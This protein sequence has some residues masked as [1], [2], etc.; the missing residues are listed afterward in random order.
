MR[1]RVAGTTD[2]I[3]LIPVDTHATDIELLM[4]GVVIIIVFL[5]QTA[6]VTPIP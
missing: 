4:D 6:F 1:V 2:I 3:V 5:I